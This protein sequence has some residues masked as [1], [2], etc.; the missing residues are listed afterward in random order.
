M[1]ISTT[2]LLA[3]DSLTLQF[4]HSQNKG[5]G[6]KGLVENTTPRVLRLSPMDQQS[7]C[8][9]AFNKLKETCP[10][11][12]LPKNLP[13]GL[14]EESFD[15]A[16]ELDFA[17][18]RIMC[19]KDAMQEHPQC[20]EAVMDVQESCRELTTVPCDVLPAADS[21]P[22]KQCLGELKTLGAEVDS[23]IGDIS[24]LTPGELQAL[25][26]SLQASY[27]ADNV[28]STNLRVAESVAATIRDCPGVDAGQCKDGVPEYPTSKGKNSSYLVSIV[29]LTGVALL[30]KLGV[31]RY[32]ST[33]STN[34]QNAPE[35]GT[36]PD[37]APQEVEFELPPLV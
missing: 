37:E 9:L 12:L 8:D 19:D 31:S 33:N 2:R 13:N 7:A 30:A 32:Q 3:A 26:D 5:L 27:C 21:D 16:L 17:M 29:T 1:H 11:S 4:S 36:R 14:G 35:Y 23:K 24:L 28:E 22:Y 6:A 34:S 18:S 25:M 20:A 15:Q 10:D